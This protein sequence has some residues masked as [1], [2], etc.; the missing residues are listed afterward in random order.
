MDP[1]KKIIDGKCL[2]WIDRFIKHTGKGIDR[3]GLADDDDIL[4]GVSGG[5]DSLSLSLGLRMLQKYHKKKFRLSAVH[6][7]WEEFPANEEQKDKLVSFFDTLEI[8][9]QIKPFSMFTKKSEKDF[10]CYFCARNRKLLIFRIAEEASIQKVAFGHHLDDH[11]ETSLMNLFFRAK[12]EPMQPKSIFFKGKIEV[13]R[14]LC[15]V[16]EYVTKKLAGFLSM[17]VIEIDCP[18]KETNLRVH[19]KALIKHLYGLNRHIRK[20]IFEA[21]DNLYR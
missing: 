2:P 5:K 1:L 9:F 10:S 3:F 8:P 21:Y 13:I 19:I 15:L 12:L 14:P 16:P 18:Y 6:I 17:P 7:D 20:H 11:I 4:I